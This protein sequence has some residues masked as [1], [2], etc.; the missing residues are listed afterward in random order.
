M[1]SKG[2][3]SRLT[4]NKR[5]MQKNVYSKLGGSL[6]VTGTLIKFRFS[7]KAKDLTTVDFKL[8]K[9]HPR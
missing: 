8:L 4:A 5:C 2:A 7:K 9:G 3:M 6:T 1:F